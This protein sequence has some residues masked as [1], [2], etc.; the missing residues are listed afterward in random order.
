[1]ANLF[2]IFDKTFDESK[3]LP[4]SEIPPTPDVPNPWMLNA[5]EQQHTTKQKACQDAIPA[6]TRAQ[7]TQ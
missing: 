2:A 5:Q 6:D 1:M 7:L 4:H 3:L